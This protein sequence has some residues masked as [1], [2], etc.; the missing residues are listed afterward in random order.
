MGTPQGVATDKAGNFYFTSLNCVFKVDQNGVMTRVAGNARAGYS[1][2][3]GPAPSAQLAGALAVAVDG[4][5]NLFIADTYNSRIR[6]VST[7]GI[8]TTI[9][10][11]GVN[12]YLGDGGPAV[13][14]Q[15]ANPTGIAVDGSG[16]IFFSDT[17]YSCFRR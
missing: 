2:D 1:G 5:G 9:A 6:R 3:G 13:S 12:G 7:S 17:T 15:L 4:A 8:I 11:N 16:N 14:A 10:G